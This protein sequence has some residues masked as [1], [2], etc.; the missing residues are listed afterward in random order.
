MSSRQIGNLGETIVAQWLQAQ[1][2]TILARSWHCRWGELDL[3]A[4]QNQPSRHLAFIEVKTRSSGSWDDG[5]LLAISP[6]KQAKL[7]KTAQLFLAQH[8]DLGDLPC[9]FDVALVRCRRSQPEPGHAPPPKTVPLSLRQPVSL[10][11]Y[12]LSLQ[13][14]IESAFE[15]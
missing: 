15:N 11:G 14:Y 2:W 1:G 12:T 3:V 6:Q 8:P 7:W 10:G 13:D 4:H 9:R 5:G